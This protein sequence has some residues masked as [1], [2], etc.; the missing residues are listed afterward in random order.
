MTEFVTTWAGLYPGDVIR[1]ADGDSWHVESV[2]PDGGRTSVGM[3]LGVAEVV[4]RVRSDSAVTVLA[5]GDVRRCAELLGAQLIGT[6]I[7]V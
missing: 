4:G 5:P 7:N 6:E 1:G 2:N 3:S